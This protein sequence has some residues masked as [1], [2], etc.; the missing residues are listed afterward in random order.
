MKILY[1]LLITCMVIHTTTNSQELMEIDGNIRLKNIENNNVENN[2][3][4]I[5]PDGVLAKRDISTIQNNQS[6][7]ISNDTIFLTSGGFVKLPQLDHCHNYEYLEEE[8]NNTEMSTILD[9]LRILRLLKPCQNTFIAGDGIDITNNVISVNP[10][11]RSPYYLGKDT[12]GGIVFYIYEDSSGSQRGFIVSKMQAELKWQ[13]N[14]VLTGAVKLHDGAYNTARMS[15][16]PI[17]DFALS[18]GEGW[19]IPSLDE[20][21]WLYRNRIHVNKSLESQNMPLLGIGRYWTSSEV[22]SSRAG[23]HSFDPLI[24]SSTGTKA[25]ELLI[26]PIKSF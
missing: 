2:I 24:L 13:N 18:L 6:L 3:L 16:S 17:K 25:E 8:I 7:S 15:D 5:Q 21:L 19:F 11:E 14:P 10:K 20:I 9:F 4:V 12:L 22:D 23:V 26:R 1:F